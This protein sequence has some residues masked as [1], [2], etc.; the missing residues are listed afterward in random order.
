MTADRWADVRFTVLTALG[1]ALFPFA[2]HLIGG[3]GGLATQI[4]ILSIAAIGFNLLLGYAGMLSYGHAM[5]YG[6]G[7]YAAAILLMQVTPTQPNLWLA[8]G[9]ATAATTLLALLVG[10]VTVRLYGIYFALV[11]LAFA[12]MIFFVVEQAKQWTNGDDG[13][14]NFPVALLPLGGVTIDLSTPLPARDLGPFGN[15]SDLHLWYIFAAIAL[16]LVLVGTRVLVRSQ[17]GEA[18]AAIRENEERSTLIGLNAAAYRLAVFAI[19]G[20]L[21]GFSGALRALNDGTVAVESLGIERSGAFVVYTIVGGVQT[22]FG[23]VVG[24]A[25]ITYLEN[26]LSAKTSAW[27]LIEGLIF[28]AVIVFLPSGIVGTIARRQAQRARALLGRTLRTQA[29]ES[30]GA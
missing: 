21:A 18:L 15:L 3:Y 10:A 30:P 5:F 6:G 27:R 25:V 16:L 23:P 11:T 9:A 1:L 19:S 7:G 20:A 17:F 4:V 26:V 28:V 8:V 14:Q 24:T 2:F 12:Q 13:L 29:P 22:V